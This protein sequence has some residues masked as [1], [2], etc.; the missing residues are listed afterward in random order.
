[1]ASKALRQ[2]TSGLLNPKGNLGDFR[3]AARMFT[4]DSFRLLPKTKFLFHVYFLIN[5]NAL[6]SLNFRYQHQ[7][8][9]GML[10]KSADL[11]KFSITT[12]TANQYN[13][14]KVIQSKIDYQAVTIKFHDDNLGVTRQ[15]WENYYSYYYADPITARQYGN[16]LRSATLNKNYIRSPYGLDN[17]SSI[18]FFEN[19]TIYQM[20]RRY[21][22]SYTLVNPIITSFSHDSLDYSNNSPAEQSMTL[23]YESVYYDNGYVQQ[24]SPPGFGIDHYDTVPSPITLAGGGSRSLFGAGGVLAGVSNVFGNVASGKAFESPEN[25][26]STAITA[27]NTYQN[28]RQLSRTGINEELVNITNRSLSTISRPGVSGI[29]NT[30]FPISDVNSNNVTSAT[31]RRLGP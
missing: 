21:W 22:N 23:A 25:F 29:R 28:S 31:S 2:F 9:I 19:I 30:S 20:A 1:M 18:P 27:V 4:D 10:V 6:K 7:N 13:R 5:T 24:N 11:P 12:D 8:E 14:K 26:L 17:N 16:Y 15:L 3:H